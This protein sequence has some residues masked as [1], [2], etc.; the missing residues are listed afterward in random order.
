MLLVKK[1][2]IGPKDTSGTVFDK[3][4]ALGGE[5]LLEGLDLLEQGKLPPV[6]QPADGVTHAAKVAKEEGLI[7][8]DVPARE[9][10][11]K[12][13]GLLPHPGAWFFYNGERISVLDADPVELNASVPAGTVCANLTVACETGGLKLNVLRRDGKKA[14]PAAD[15]LRGFDLPEGAVLNAQI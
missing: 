10:D 3:L 7:S 2:P 6:K 5:A 4:A 12:I 8:F 13:R 15:F 11:C 9:L 1:L 14:V